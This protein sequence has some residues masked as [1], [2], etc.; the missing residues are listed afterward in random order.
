MGNFKP[1][2]IEGLALN[3]VELLQRARD[4]AGVPFIITSGYRSPAS[5]AAAGG[6]NSSLHCQG[7]AVDLRAPQGTFD[8]DRILWGLA[9]AGFKQVGFYTNHVHVELDPKDTIAMWTGV[10]K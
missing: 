3:F 5:N 8:R 2:E 6:V 9:H 10:S 7:L 1:S 4:I